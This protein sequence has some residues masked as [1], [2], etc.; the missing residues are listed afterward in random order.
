MDMKRLNTWERQILRM[1]YALEAEQDIWRIRT[2]REL[3]KAV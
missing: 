3:A 2:D 1:I